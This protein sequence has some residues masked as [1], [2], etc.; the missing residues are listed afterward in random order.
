MADTVSG[1]DGI[2]ITLIRHVENLVFCKEFFNLTA[3]YTKQWTD[4]TIPYRLYSSQSAQTAST[5]H[6]EKNGF[7]LI[8]FMVCQCNFFLTDSLLF[9]YLI[10]KN[11]G[12]F[13]YSGMVLFLI[14]IYIDFFDAAGH[15]PCVAKIFYKSRFLIRFFPQTVVNMNGGKRKRNFFFYLT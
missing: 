15:L 4:V 6:L 3:C 10:A 8:I 9:K 2:K 5:K 13:L 7:C 11:S 14:G 12:R 1:I